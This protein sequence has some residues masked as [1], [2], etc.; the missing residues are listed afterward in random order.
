MW[1][2]LCLLCALLSLALPAQAIGPDNPTAGYAEAGLSADVL[3]DTACLDCGEPV[4][5][6]LT[7]AKNSAPDFVLIVIDGGISEGNPCQAFA[8]HRFNGVETEV[9]DKIRAWIRKDA[10]NP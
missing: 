10:R 8:Y 3:I 7:P 5:Y 6:I 9:A 4:A 1:S 2:C